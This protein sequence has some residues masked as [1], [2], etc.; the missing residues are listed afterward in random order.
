MVPRGLLIARNAA[1]AAGFALLLAS[2]G[3]TGD[4]PGVVAVEVRD[5]GYIAIVEGPEGPGVYASQDGGASFAPSSVEAGTLDDDR[6]ACSEDGCVQIRGLTI[7][8]GPTP[9]FDIP[10]SRAQFMSCTSGDCG[11]RPAAYIDVAAGDGEAGQLLAIVAAGVDG[12][13]VKVDGT[14]WRRVAVGPHS[15]RPTARLFD[16]IGSAWWWVI[17]PT[18]IALL[19]LFWYDRWLR[20][21]RWFPFGQ[22]LDKKNRAFAIA[23]GIVTAGVL[24]A[25]VVLALWTV[26]VIAWRSDAVRW[27]RLVALVGAISGMTASVVLV[28]RAGG[29]TRPP[30]QPA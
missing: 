21:E 17:A 16:G 30:D 19:Y 1:L 12:V 26:D 24:A 10:R 23:A 3:G 18:A 20:S 15:P 28:T 8:E 13:V 4:P 5:A 22:A 7:F 6:I 29:R 27:A 11:S 25:V 14:E 9:I 2:C